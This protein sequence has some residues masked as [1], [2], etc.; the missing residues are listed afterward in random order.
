[1]KLGQVGWKVEI[2]RISGCKMQKTENISIAEISLS[3][4]KSG[5]LNPNDV[6]RIAAGISEMAVSARAQ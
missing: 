4:T 3:C 5:S 1:M 2:W 6:V